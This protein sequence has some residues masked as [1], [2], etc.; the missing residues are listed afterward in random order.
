MS[1]VF[2]LLEVLV[3]A[4][5]VAIPVGSAQMLMLHSTSFV[6]GAQGHAPARAADRLYVARRWPFIWAVFGQIALFPRV[7]G[8]LAS[9][10]T[11]GLKLLSRRG[12]GGAVAA[13]RPV[14]WLQSP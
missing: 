8:C 5:L 12:S 3:A 14:K 13:S 6:H 7:T 10:E 4:L 2:T 1:R 11:T 9:G